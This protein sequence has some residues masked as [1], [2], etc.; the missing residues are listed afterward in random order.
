MI[1]CILCK[2][3]NFKSVYRDNLVSIIT[4]PCCGLVRQENCASSLVKINENF[5]NIEEYYKRRNEIQK[6][7]IVFN[8]K[9][10]FY[11]L[12]IIKKIEKQLKEGDLILDIGCGSGEFLKGLND[13]GF[14]VLGVEPDPLLAA[15]VIEQLKIPVIVDTYSVHLFPKNHF[16]GITFI[17]VFEHLE[18][19]LKTLKQ[20]YTNLKLGGLLII[21]VPSYNNPRILCYRLLR[22]KKIVKRDFIP[23]HC[24]YYTRSTLSKLVE[25]AGFFVTEIVT[26][27]Y[28]AKFGIHNFF[29]STTDK[30]ANR[31]GIGGI[32]IYA[33]K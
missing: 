16:N 1:N 2:N 10:C 26:G 8:Q 4:C 31:I 18:D 30:I 21:D 13:S 23:S 9:K 28:G 27:R 3:Q 6:K 33:R 19:P 12:D 25:K 14:D 7:T 11:S 17:Q 5:H 32:T 29:M 22:W 24:Y 20:V 15:F